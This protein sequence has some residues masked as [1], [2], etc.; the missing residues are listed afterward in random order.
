MNGMVSLSTSVV[1]T[2]S[3]GHNG[4]NDPILSTIYF[5]RQSN[6]RNISL[7]SLSL[8]FLCRENSYQVLGIISILNS[9]ARSKQFHINTET[10]VV[11]Q[12]M[13]ICD[14]LRS[15]SQRNAFTSG[16]R[17]SCRKEPAMIL[18]QATGIVYG[19]DSSKKIIITYG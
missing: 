14:Y 3:A 7:P 8:L 12:I 17:V 13:C 15:H 19:N 16:R 6:I 11:I 4:S 5:I 2:E 9:E 1:F 18:N 10:S